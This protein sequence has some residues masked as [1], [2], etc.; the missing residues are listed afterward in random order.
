MEIALLRHGKPELI[1]NGKLSAFEYAKYMQRYDV[2]G[3]DLAH[4]PPAEVSL[5]AE[6]SRLILCSDLRRAVESA[7][8]LKANDKLLV[9]PVFQEV[10]LPGIRMNSLRLSAKAWGVVLRAAWFFGYSNGSESISQ[11]RKRAAA[12]ADHLTQLA[13]THGSV[14]LVGHGFINYFI[15]R[16]LLAN[17]WDGP[18]IPSWKYWGVAL[19]NL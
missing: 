1:E 19:Y 12:A 8:V 2:A 6:Q 4:Q 13:R 3:I 18:S 11:A 5:R 10:K 7:R 16:A 9:E 15:G 17:G 14:M